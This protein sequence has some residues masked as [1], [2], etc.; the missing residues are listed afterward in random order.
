VPNG[1]IDEARRAF[2]SLAARDQ[3]SPRWT[4]LRIAASPFKSHS[5]LIDE[6]DP[7]GGG[8]L[9]P[10]LYGSERVPSDEF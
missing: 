1:P 6:A 3:S 5:L 4:S 7:N 8:Q 10:S 2:G 9:R